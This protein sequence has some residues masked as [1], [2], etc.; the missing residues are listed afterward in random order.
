M[1]ESGVDS[2]W[3]YQSF[4][5]KQIMYY[6][7]LVR[8]ADGTLYCGST[9]DPGRRIAQHN[10]GAGSAYVYTH[11]GGK[12]VYTET[13][14]TVGDALRREIQIKKLARRR[15]ENLILGLKP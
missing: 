11:G 9:R 8:C 3:G 10:T 15:K 4:L 6:C 14:A 2:R 12:I 1:W 7:Y 5:K 13:F